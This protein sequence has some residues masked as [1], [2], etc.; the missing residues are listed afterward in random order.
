[1]TYDRQTITVL[2]TVPNDNF[3]AMTISTTIPMTVQVTISKT[4]SKMPMT[5]PVTIPK[6][7]STVPMTV[8]V[9]IST[10]P[11]TAPMTIPIT[12]PDNTYDNSYNSYDT[13]IWSLRLSR[14]AALTA[15]VSALA[16]R[17]WFRSYANPASTDGAA[18]VSWKELSVA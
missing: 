7:I 2:T 3:Y 16:Q 12:I 13:L 6:T 14:P 15:G 10:I 18:A 17:M 4:I 9:T 1:M 8:Q 11:M 5:V